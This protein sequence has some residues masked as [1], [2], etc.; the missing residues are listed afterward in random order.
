M[1]INVAI[2][3]LLATD[4]VSLNDGQERRMKP[5]VA[6]TPL[7]TLPH[8]PYKR[9]LNLERFNVPRSPLHGGSS[10]ALGS[11]SHAM[12]TTSSLP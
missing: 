2:Q 12:P 7:I 8:H 6:P 10:A 4:L 3:E 5:E 11:N 9:T 1:N